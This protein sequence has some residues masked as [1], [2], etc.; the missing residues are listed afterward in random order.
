MSNIATNI[1]AALELIAIC[2]VV[3]E[4]INKGVFYVKSI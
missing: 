3:H 1:I 2:M 4:I